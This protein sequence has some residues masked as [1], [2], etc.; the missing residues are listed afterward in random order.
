MALGTTVLAIVLAIS[1]YVESIGQ[2]EVAQSPAAIAGIVVSFSVVPAAI[3]A[4]SLLVLARYRLRKHD[5][6]AA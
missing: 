6:E 3:M 5:I 4:L 2:Q 1:G